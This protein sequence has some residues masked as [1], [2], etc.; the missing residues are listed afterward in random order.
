MKRSDRVS[1]VSIR[2]V[3]APRGVSDE[4]VHAC[5]GFGVLPTAARDRAPARVPGALV[6]EIRPGRVVL[7]AGASGAGKSTI[8]GALACSLE[9]RGV[10]RVAERFSEAESGR[11]VF[12]CLGGDPRRRSGVLALAGLAEPTLWARAAGALSEGEGARVRL[13]IAMARAEPGSVVLADEFASTLD[14]VTAYALA[15]TVRRWARRERVAIVASSAHEDLEACLA[16]DVV[17]DAAT[18]MVRAPREASVQRVRV[19]QGS[20]DDYRR[21]SHLHYRTG[22]PASVVRVLRCVREVP[23]HIDPAGEL[24]AGVLCVSMP[25]L[26]GA[27]RDRAWAGFFSTGDKRRDARRLN[28]HLRTISRVIVDPRSRGMGVATALVRSYLR[29]PL[30]RGTEA[31]AA[32][33][34]V[35][36]FFE[37]AGMAGYDLP[38]D[39]TDTRL[40]DALGHMGIA[41]AQLARTRLRTGSLLERELTTWG[42]RRKLLRAG[43]HSLEEVQRLTPTAACRLCSRPRAYAYTK[44]DRGDEEHDT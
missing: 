30:T 34:C 5:V 7:L 36:P 11:A 23:R 4:L 35:C 12:V 39:L 21:V 13:A 32:M 31:R 3:G 42:K 37:R 22:A 19:E 9:G 38:P 28:T 1:R 10:V 2:R 18:G 14:R 40:L 33:G 29:N 17:F 26:N 8:L 44:G 25:T 27:W 43:N 6:R 41:P 16:P 24:L 15:R 20:M